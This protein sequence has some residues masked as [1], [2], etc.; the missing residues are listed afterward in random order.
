MGLADFAKKEVIISAGTLD[1]PKILMHSGVGPAEQLQQFHIPVVRD[2]PAIGQGLKDHLF[3]PVAFARNPETNDRNAFFGHEATMDAAMKQWQENCSGPW[4]R[5]SCQVAAGWF[6]SDRITSSDE[7]KALPASV[8]EFLQRETVPHYE[9]A[10]PFPIHLCHPQWGPDFSYICIAVFMLNEQST[11][12]VLL[13]SSNPDDP[14]LFDPK[15]LNHPFDRR[16]CVESYRHVLEV[17]KHHSFTKDNLSTLI[18]PSSESDYDILEFWK[19]NL[20]SSWHM[21]GTVKMGK[22]GDADAAVDSRFRL[23]GI[24][25]LRV[26]DM[27]VVPVLTNN[28]TQATAYVT[29]AT[30]AEILVREYNLD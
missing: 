26:A 28:H 24:E 21:I 8:Q 14:L 29:G 3:A 19:N 10:A 30:C 20:C 15:F 9:L 5:H 4:A 7:F 12:E 11:G 6:K 27:S 17:T 22:L 25:S 18:A 23:F 2:L 13:Q 1:T 16:A